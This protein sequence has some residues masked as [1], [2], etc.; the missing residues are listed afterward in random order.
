MVHKGS[1]NY[2]F[3]FQGTQM[4]SRSGEKCQKSYWTTLFLKLKWPLFDSKVFTVQCSLKRMS[5]EKKIIR[6]SLDGMQ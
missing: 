2:I 6:E 5:I 3:A 1:S 4:T